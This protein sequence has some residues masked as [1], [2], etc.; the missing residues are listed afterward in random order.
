MQGNGIVVHLNE[1]EEVRKVLDVVELTDI[2]F[3]NE[4]V[5]VEGKLR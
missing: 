2:T 1:I 5:I 4:S 3:Q